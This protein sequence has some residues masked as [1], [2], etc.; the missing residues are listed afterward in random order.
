M[1][2]MYTLCTHT[3][4]AAA[5]RAVLLPWRFPKSPVVANSGAWLLPTALFLPCAQGA[6]LQLGH[7][8]REEAGLGGV[9]GR[10]SED[11]ATRGL[12][13]GALARG[14]SPVAVAQRV[15][16]Q[17]V[18]HHGQHH[19]AHHDQEEAR[20][21]GSLLHRWQFLETLR[22]SAGGLRAPQQRDESLHGSLMAEDALA[23]IKAVVHACRYN[24]GRMLGVS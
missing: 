11:R 12:V 21:T 16:A 18:E 2:I 23:R 6:C 17:V 15:W 20:A 22:V 7:F 8:F 10:T 5:A 14:L 19:P 1:C 4:H 13:A 9:P 3:R 24:P